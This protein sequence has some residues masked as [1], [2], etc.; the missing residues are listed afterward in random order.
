M[1]ATPST[2]SR[3]QVNSPVEILVYAVPDHQFAYTVCAQHHKPV[4][5]K[6]TWFDPFFVYP[7]DTPFKRRLRELV[8]RLTERSDAVA[9]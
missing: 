4:L 8:L 7:P 1:D 5:H 3:Y 2:A 6:H 9:F